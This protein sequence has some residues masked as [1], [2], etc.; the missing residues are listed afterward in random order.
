M[1]VNFSTLVLSATATLF[2]ASYSQGAI[3]ESVGIVDDINDMTTSAS[4][5][6]TFETDGLG[7]GWNF[8]NP[9]GVQQVTT[10]LN[11]TSLNPSIFFSY[12]DSSVA[13]GVYFNDGGSG[14]GYPNPVLRRNAISSGGSPLDGPDQRI[15]NGVTGTGGTVFSGPETV[16]IDFRFGNTPAPDGGVAGDPAYMDAVAFDLIV[17][18]GVSVDVQY[19]QTRSD[20]DFLIHEDLGITGGSSMV[21]RFV[22][23]ERPGV[24]PDPGN[25][26]RVKIT[27]SGTP[28]GGVTENYIIDDFQTGTF[29]ATAVPEPSSFAFA[30]MAGGGWVARRVRRKKIA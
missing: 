24:L 2:F 6:V 23:Y 18:A 8:Q 28:T 25:F 14:S 12:E 16:F 20:G 5:V 7:S 9:E 29:T 27:F 30:L 3:S 26:N 15:S 22:G 1:R 13:G 11:S 10:Q 4:Q 17:S 19:L 21:P